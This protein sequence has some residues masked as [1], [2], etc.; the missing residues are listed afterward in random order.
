MNITLP[1]RFCSH[2]NLIQLLADNST[3][4]DQSDLV[5]FQLP[6]KC[7]LQS[8]AIAFLCAWGMNT[9]MAG[10][11][12]QF[13]GNTHYLAR[14]DFFQHLGIE[15]EEPF[16][17]HSEQG[18]FLPLR[19][20][21]NEIDVFHT[22]NAICDLVLHQFEGAQ[23]F[24]PALEWAV[25][26]IIDNIHTHAETTIP[27][28]VCAQYYPQKDRLDIGI[29]DMGRG[30]KASLSESFTLHDHQEAISKALERGVTRNPKFGAGNGLAGSLAIAKQN[31]AEFHLWS[32]DKNFLL[33]R[34]QTESF[35]DIPFIWGTGILF[36]LNTRIPV[37]LRNTFIASQNDWNYIVA[38]SGRVQDEGGI[39][40][41]DEC[42][43]F[44]S[45]AAARPLRVK[46][47]N[48]LPECE[49]GLT[50]DFQ[51]VDKPTSS[52]LDE[53]IG[54]LAQ[55][56]GVEQFRQ[57]I[58]II[59]TSDVVRNMLN[60]VIQ[61]RFYPTAIMN[62]SSPSS[63]SQDD[64]LILHLIAT[65]LMQLSYQVD[66]GSPLK[67]PYPEALQKGLNKLTAKFLQEGKAPPQGIPD[68]IRMAHLPLQTWQ[69]DLP[70]EAV[71]VHD[72]LFK[73]NLPTDVCTEWAYETQDV[74]GELEEQ[75]VMK[76]ALTICRNQ[77]IPLTY[78]AFRRLLI[79]K[80]VLT[81][82]S[83]QEQITNSLLRPLT[84]VLKSAYDQPSPAH[85]HN[86]NFYCCS[87]CGNLLFRTRFHTFVCEHRECA[88]V[89]QDMS[90]FISSNEGVVWLRRSLRRFVSAP[91]RFELQLERELQKLLGKE[92][93]EMW[94]QYDQYDL[95]LTFPNG[96]IWAV[97]VKDWA[98]PFLLARKTKEFAATPPWDKAFFVFPDI[99][100]QQR[101][102]YVR[103]FSA[104]YKSSPGKEIRA[105]FARDFISLVKQELV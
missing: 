36:R 48:L 79:E 12:L 69:L 39:R 81:A 40:V 90:R 4:V 59:H 94:P 52:F 33:D 71:G 82:F 93:V 92:A 84:E 47:L 100:R 75:N 25:N 101:P 65:G 19:L 6:K 95:R 28:V 97:D 72:A 102:D 10:K 37:D 103:A 86:G 16:R 53:L 27:G 83:F 26:E 73:N 60:V 91:G 44:S 17:R 64:E 7:F 104:Y 50:L 98:N 96:K 34:S 31:Q 14:M 58:N 63:I 21:T 51:D 32:G 3:Q 49:N 24:L 57:Q 61:D 13:E 22:T 9:K 80:P 62:V 8:S 45:R 42:R 30:I 56:L 43:H 85:L 35:T 77:N 46:I 23:A 38:E 68:L 54:L 1:A 20:V 78:V 76:Q 89:I 67:L 99:R 15:Y 105:W 18:R 55:K 70:P 2:L 74:E 29:Y 5:T 41:K 66:K 88:T 11:K 87:N